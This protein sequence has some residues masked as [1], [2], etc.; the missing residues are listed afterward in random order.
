MRSRILTFG[1]ISA[2]AFLSPAAAADLQTSDKQQLLQPTPASGWIVTLSGKTVPK[3]SA[4]RK[5]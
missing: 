3:V 4:F 1:T 2:L 5:K